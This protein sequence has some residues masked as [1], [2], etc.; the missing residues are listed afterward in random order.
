MNQC[1][2]AKAMVV[3]AR[4]HP[5]A[6]TSKRSSLQW[7]KALYVLLKVVKRVAADGESYAA[8]RDTNERF[9]DTL[10]GRGIPV[11]RAK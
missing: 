6:L 10:R 3:P 11:S 9:L 7:E 5:Q 8:E 1:P 2:M 4:Q